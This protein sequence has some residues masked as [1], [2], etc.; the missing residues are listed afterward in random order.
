MRARNLAA[1]LVLLVM[2]AV[3]CS[4]APVSAGR[5]TVDSEGHIRGVGDAN[6]FPRE[7]NY[8][9][10]LV[11]AADSSAV[12]SNLHMTFRLYNAET[13]GTELWSETHPVVEVTRGLF[14]IRLGTVTPFPEDL[15]D[16]PSL[17]LQTEVGSEVLSPRKLLASVAYGMRSQTADAATYAGDAHHAIHADTAAYSLVAMTAAAESAAVSADAYRLE[18]QTLTQL[19]ARWVNETDLDHLDAADGNPARALSVDGAG[20]VGIGTASPTHTLD[21]DGDVSA[22]SYYGDGSHLSGVAGEP[23]ADWV[24]DGDDIY[25][26]VGRVGIGTI[27]PARPLD[28]TGAIQ[29]DTLFLGAGAGGHLNIARNQ[30]GDV[31]FK[32]DGDHSA[33]NPQVEISGA[34]QSVV[35]TMSQTGDPSVVLPGNALSAPEMLDEPG[36]ASIKEGEVAVD[37]TG[38]VEILLSRS[39]TVPLNGYV[40]AIATVEAN[41][42]HMNGVDSWARF[43]VSMESANLPNNQ[44]VAP[45]LPS[46]APSGVYHFPV[47][48]HGLFQVT[49][50]V[51]TFYLLGDEGYGGNWYAW[52]MQLTLI[53][54]R[55]AYGQVT[56]TMA[57]GPSPPEELTPRVPA[58]TEQQAAAERAEAEAF[59]AARM[60]RE[61]V[62]IRA[63][64]EALK[65]KMEHHD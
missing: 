29:A 18:G 11:S 46:T 19:D 40:L 56:P 13:E 8:Q 41:V 23:D 62:A 24:V 38:P 31:G 61:M 51:R 43:G 57:G 7:L 15:F 49:P 44:D 39:L 4:S 47:T 45:Q 30:A 10:Y 54:F 22:T 1:F 34:S 35:F 50:G 28:V 59:H 48:P 65:R 17:W 63:E 14:S 60:E 5:E 64:L 26:Q 37:L 33:N 9:G 16:G 52:D 2:I 12:T 6:S 20:R 36:V 3:L 58:L 53:Y 27:N 21:V 32:V 42:E 55:T 25:H